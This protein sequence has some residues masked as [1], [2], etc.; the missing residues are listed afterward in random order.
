MPMD[1]RG[2]AWVA[3]SQAL[4]GAILSGAAVSVF[5]LASGLAFLGRALAAAALALLFAAVFFL[6]GLP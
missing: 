4:S 1:A 3:C 6:A 2:G 5:G